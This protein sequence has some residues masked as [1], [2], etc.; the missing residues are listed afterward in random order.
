M[1]LEALQFV[2]E[3]LSVCAQPTRLRKFF[4][5]KFQTHLITKD[6]INMK[7]RGGRGGRGE[8]GGRGISI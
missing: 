3:S 2:Q 8:R 7:S 4:Y 5:E 1:A 6:I